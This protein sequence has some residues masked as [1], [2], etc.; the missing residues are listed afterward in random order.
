MDKLEVLVELVSETNAFQAQ[1]GH[2]LITNGIAGFRNIDGYGSALINSRM[3]SLSDKLGNMLYREDKG[4]WLSWSKVDWLKLVERVFLEEYFK[5][6]KL[7]ETVSSI[8]DL[9]KAIEAKISYQSHSGAIRFLSGCDIFSNS[10]EEVIDFGKVSIVGRGRWLDKQCDAGILS[11][12]IC[13][14]IKL[15]WGLDGNQVDPITDSMDIY[16]K[17]NVLDLVGR[18]GYVCE[19]DVSGLV[20]EAAEAKAIMAMNFAMVAICLTWNKPSKALRN[21]S[22]TSCGYPQLVYSAISVDGNLRGNSSRWNGGFGQPLIETNWNEVSKQYSSVFGVISEVIDYALSSTGDVNRP[23][24]MDTF[25]HSLMW[26]HEACKEDLPMIA[27]TKFVA[28][29]DALASNS[30]GAGGIIRVITSRLGV[31][32][33]DPIRPEGPSFK[34]AITEIY[35]QGRSRLLHGSSDRLMQ[36]WQSMRNLAEEFSRLA[37]IQCLDLASRKPLM[38]D[39]KEMQDPELA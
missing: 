11:K 36:D 15:Q 4:L 19:V 25:A 3:K 13:D 39:P 9:L 37:I 16:T 8:K 29:L 7:Y 20:G 12:L 24:L 10:I 5:N 14:N 31:S 26:F 22:S 34:E 33:D 27:I 23:R 38:N 2:S 17:S 28:S 18:G 1:K 35:S 32:K 21:M 6:L 30:A